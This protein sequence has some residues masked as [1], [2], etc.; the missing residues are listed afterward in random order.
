MLAGLP[1]FAFHPLGFEQRRATVMRRAA[2]NAARLEAAATLEPAEALARL[3]AIPGV[4]PW[5]A[6]E[7]AR[8]AFGDPDAVSVGD[9]HLK[10]VVCWALACEP[11]GTDER[12]LDLLEPWAGHRARV[13][14]L[15]ETGGRMP[16]RYGPRIAPRDLV[17][18]APR[19]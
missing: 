17:D 18:L 1:Y 6:A 8:S 16:P 2:Q 5:T 4:G 9:F 11:R 19:R 13:I 3:Q 15:L 7:T 10:N 14:R 12:M